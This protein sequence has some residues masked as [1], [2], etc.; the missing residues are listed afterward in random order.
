MV[1]LVSPYEVINFHG[2]I[3][4]YVKELYQNKES[5]KS[6]ASLFNH[7]FIADIKIHTKYMNYN[8]LS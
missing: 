4:K 1:I 6:N 2:E 7:T 5:D 8:N 3:Y